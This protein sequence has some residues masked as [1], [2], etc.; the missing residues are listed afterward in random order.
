METRLIT[1]L[2]IFFTVFTIVAAG[3]W[4]FVPR[5][6]ER[7]HR[8]EAHEFAVFRSE[9]EKLKV[10]NPRK[11]VEYFRD[12]LDE[13]ESAKITSGMTETLAEF[14]RGVATS[15]EE[16]PSVRE[17]ARVVYHS[18]EARGGGRAPASVE[19]TK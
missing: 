6:E 4:A 12:L 19:S 10:Q 8:F 2:T 11:R 18:L 1:R 9:Y 3:V 5:A 17:E 7:N 14:C 15:E 13:T 16:S